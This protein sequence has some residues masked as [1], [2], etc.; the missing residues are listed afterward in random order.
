MLGADVVID[1]EDED[2]INLMASHWNS[3]TA[4]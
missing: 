4:P 1:G 2:F 3:W